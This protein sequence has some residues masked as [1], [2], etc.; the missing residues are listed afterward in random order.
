MLN[1]TTI[2]DAD[3]LSGSS[4]LDTGVKSTIKDTLALHGYCLLRNFAGDRELFDQL[5]NQLCSTVTF[6]P[7]RESLNKSLQKVDAGTAKIGLHIENGNTP[8]IPELVFFYCQQ[9]AKHGSRTTL[10]DGTQLLALLPAELQTLFGKPLTITRT[11]PEALWKSYLV[12][13]HPMLSE[14]DQVSSEHLQQ[15]LSARP[16]L[17]GTVNS[18]DSFTY[19]LTIHPLME[20][21]MGK[22]SAFANAI[23][24][25]SFNYEPPVYEFADGTIV[26]NELKNQLAELA[27]SV[28]I[29]IPWQSGDIAIIDNWRVMHGRRE[30]TDAENRKLFIGMGNL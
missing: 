11:L 7:A 3:T 30:I 23:L 8:N 5:V 10:C 4:F 17:T 25:P 29:E 21:K 15:M 24:G 27:E 9:A 16:E 26:S 18:D 14:V 20:S 2:I 22:H 28:T 1:K 6:D 13:E 12:N 19:R